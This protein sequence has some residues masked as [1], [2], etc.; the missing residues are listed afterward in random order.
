MDKKG[1]IVLVPITSTAPPKQCDP[2]VPNVKHE[3]SC[4]SFY[5]CDDSRHQLVLKE[6]GPGTLFNPVSMICDWPNAVSL[7]RPEC[8][9]G[10][11]WHSTRYTYIKRSLQYPLYSSLATSST[12]TEKPIILRSTTTSFKKLY[13][14]PDT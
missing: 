12:T 10:D 6:C 11:T 1:K 4:K 9:E 8:A 5:H 7:V 3:T 13:C 14:D 2:A